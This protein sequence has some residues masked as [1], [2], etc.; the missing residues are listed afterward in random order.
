MNDLQFQ[1]ELCELLQRAGW[2]ERMERDRQDIFIEW[3]PLGRERGQHFIDEVR[4]LRPDHA[5]TDAE[6]DALRAF[7]IYVGFIEPTRRDR[8]VWWPRTS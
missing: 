5:W 8:S 6:L 2:I 7:G 4:A 3:T 1:N